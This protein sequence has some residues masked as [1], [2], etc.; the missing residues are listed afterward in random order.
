MITLHVVC[1]AKVFILA[2]AAPASARV[3]LFLRFGLSLGYHL[4]H[5]VVQVF[6]VC[7][8][9]AEDR[10][11]TAE[12][13]VCQAILRET[14]NFQPSDYSNYFAFIGLTYAS[15]QVLTFGPFCAAFLHDSA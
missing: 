12:T 3:I 14:F 4:F 8:V 6:L 5:P 15:S 1:C 2:V 11:H 9:C 10:D 7:V 13:D